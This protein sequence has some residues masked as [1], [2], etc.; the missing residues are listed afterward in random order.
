MEEK[1]KKYIVTM[2]I[3]ILLFSIMF[4]INCLSFAADDG[5]WSIGSRFWYAKWNHQGSLMIDPT[6]LFGPVLTYDFSNN[7]WFIQGQALF[8]RYHDTSQGRVV[9]DSERLDFD[10]FIGRRLESCGEYVGWGLGWKLTKSP[11]GDSKQQ[12]LTAYGPSV[13]L[14]GSTPSLKG[15]YLY[16]N[17][18]YTFLLVD[19]SGLENIP[20]SGQGYIG[21]GGLGY[22]LSNWTLT[23]GYRYQMFDAGSG[24]DS[25]GK[26]ISIDEKFSGP[27]ASVTYSF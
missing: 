2:S 4:S 9:V 18:S 16:G 12:E 21:E 22:N 7:P 23:L 3:G 24:R 27:I 19:K 17:G 20:A 10:V 26:A 8:G 6:L 11:F 1:M 13:I 14:F 15:F 5:N 25:A